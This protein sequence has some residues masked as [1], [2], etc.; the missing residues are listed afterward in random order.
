V[1]VQ[2]VNFRDIEFLMLVSFITDTPIRQVRQPMSE[3][4][5][6]RRESIKW[7]ETKLCPTFFHNGRTVTVD[8]LENHHP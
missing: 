7:F 4:D 8:I 5:F 3:E 2:N 6:S 1:L